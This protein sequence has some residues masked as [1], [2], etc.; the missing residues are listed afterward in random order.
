MHNSEKPRL[1]IVEDDLGLQ[2]QLKWCFDGYEVL[3]ATTRNE[4]LAQLRR[5]EPR[6]VLQDLGLPPDPEGVEEG[7][8]TLRDILSLAPQT[9]VIVVTGHNDRDN[10]VRAVSLGAYDFYLKPV[11]TESLRLIVSRAFYIYELEEENRKLREAQFSAPFEGLIATDDAMLRVCRMVERVGPTDV[12]VLIWGESG[13]G[14]E[15]IARAIHRQSSRRER[16]FVAINCAAIPEHVLDSELFGSA[17]GDVQD[18]HEQTIGKL[19]LASGG[20]VFLDEIG[21][22]PLALQAKLLRFLQDRVIERAGRD[23]SLAADVRI[24]AATSK[25]LP[26]LIAEQAFRQDLYFRLGE[27]TINVP[28]LRERPGGAT[29]LAH[30]MLRKF[31]AIHSKGKPKRGFTQDALAALEAYSWPGNVRELENKVKTAIIM[32]EGPLITAEDLGLREAGNG[33]LLFN[34]REVRGRAERRAIQQAL[35]ITDGNISR[36]AE[37]LGVSRPTLYDLLNKYGIQH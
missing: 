23:E 11:D 5:F 6:V 4:A 17:K 10:A 12:S 37:L 30:A 16:R 34:L 14:K 31:S 3:T 24:I 7:M 35:S 22:M 29:V 26:A 8:H 9:K 33:E 25:D 20:T 28:P 2:K 1:L 36:T 27:V 18:S 32:A 15:L 21:E 19:V 13:T